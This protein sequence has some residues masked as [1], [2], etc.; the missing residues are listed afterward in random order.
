MAVKMFLL[1][2][3]AAGN[4]HFGD[5]RKPS[6]RRAL[7]QPRAVPNLREDDTVLLSDRWEQR[8]S[9][10]HTDVKIKF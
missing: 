10:A 2:L 9:T 6:Q 3:S 7:S 5:I 4:E 8:Y 1:L